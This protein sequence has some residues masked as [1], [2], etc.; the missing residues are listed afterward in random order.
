VRNQAL[1]LSALS[2]GGYGREAVF[3]VVDDASHLT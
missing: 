1:G 2:A 3:G